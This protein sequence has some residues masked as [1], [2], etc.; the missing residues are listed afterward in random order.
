M[1]L[2]TEGFLG[3]PGTGHDKTDDWVKKGK[4]EI[5]KLVSDAKHDLNKAGSDIEHKLDGALD[6]AKDQIEEWVQAALDEI[7]ARGIKYILRKILQLAAYAAPSKV[8]EIPVI[9]CTPFTPGIGVGI[10]LQQNIDTLKHYV[11]HPPHDS[12]TVLSMIRDLANDEDIFI[13]L[14]S[15]TGKIWVSGDQVDEIITKLAG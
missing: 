1:A 15:G 8:S 12:E 9:P 14:P 7:K 10:D 13:V 5:N 6:D 3:I 2:E 4:H 11:N